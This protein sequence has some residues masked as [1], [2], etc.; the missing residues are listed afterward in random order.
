MI[1]TSLTTPDTVSLHKNLQF[2][3]RNKIENIMIEAS[4][5]GLEQ[6][7]LD[8]INLKGGIFTNFSQTISIITKPWSLTSTQS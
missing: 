7:R 6:K 5:H 1:K 2:L 8:H 3:K 4:S